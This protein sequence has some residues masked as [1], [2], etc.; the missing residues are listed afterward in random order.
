[1]THIDDDWDD[2]DD[3]VTSFSHLRTRNPHF[4]AHRLFVR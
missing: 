4:L 2:D 1:M 3:N